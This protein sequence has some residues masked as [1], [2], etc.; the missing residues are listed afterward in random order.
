MIDKW[1]YTFHIIFLLYF[2]SLF[3]GRIIISVALCK[4]QVFHGGTISMIVTL[5]VSIE[6]KLKEII[7]FTMASLIKIIQF[8][9][10]INKITISLVSMS[11]VNKWYISTNKYTFYLV[12]KVKSKNKYSH[13]ILSSIKC[14]NRDRNMDI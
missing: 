6:L 9:N 12:L 11:K 2:K 3:G 10:L 5:F 8:L 7:S 1:K 4:G 14:V 13:N